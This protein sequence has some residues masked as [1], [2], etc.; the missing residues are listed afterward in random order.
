YNVAINLN[1]ITDSNTMFSRRVFDCLACGTCIMSNYSKGVEKL[2]SD[3]VKFVDNQKEAELFLEKVINDELY[4]NKLGALGIRKVI[5]QNKYSDRLKYIGNIIGLNIKEGDTKKV[6]VVVS[7]NRPKNMDMVFVNFVKQTYPYKELIIILNND[8]MTLDEWEKKAK[9]YPNEDIRIFK[10]PNKTPLGS[11]LNYALDRAK[12][13]YMC[14]M[15]DDDIYTKYYLEDEL[16]YFDYT[17]ASIIGKNTFYAYFKDTN[18]LALRYPNKEYMYTN[19]IAGSAMIFKRE[20]YEAVR[21]ND[22]LNVSEIADFLQGAMAKGFKIFSTNR[23]NHAVVRRDDLSSH[24]WQENEKYY[25]QRCSIIN[26]NCHY[27][28]MENYI[29]FRIN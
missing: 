17:E 20:V 24:T 9:E 2:F 19:L 10:L 13:D 3:V 21:F 25:L 12:Y 15:D 8:N 16:I 11:C 7:T 29:N 1:T 18:K 4:R 5:D 14:K 22:R 26:Q 23:F 6:S 28:N 27:Y